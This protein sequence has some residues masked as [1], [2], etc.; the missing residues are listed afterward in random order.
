MGMNGDI[1][2]GVRV[3]VK[4]CCSSSQNWP[5]TLSSKIMG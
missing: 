4:R 1:V 3:L 2:K 5:F